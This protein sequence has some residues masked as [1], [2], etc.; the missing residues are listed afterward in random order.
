MVLGG[1]KMSP[2]IFHHVQS[3]LQFKHPGLFTLTAR[4][5]VAAS[6]LFY[7]L[8]SHDTLRPWM[9]NE[10]KIINDICS[11]YTRQ[12]LESWHIYVETVTNP[13]FRMCLVTE[14]PKLPPQCKCPGLTKFILALYV[15]ATGVNSGEAYPFSIEELKARH[16][17]TVVEF[18][19]RTK[20]AMSNCLCFDAQREADALLE[21]AWSTPMEDGDGITVGYHILKHSC[22]LQEAKARFSTLVEMGLS[23]EGL[24]DKA[25]KEAKVTVRQLKA[26]KYYQFTI[27]RINAAFKNL[28]SIC[29]HGEEVSFTLTK[30]ELWGALQTANLIPNGYERFAAYAPPKTPTKEEMTAFASKLAKDQ[31]KKAVASKVDAMIEECYITN[32]KTHHSTLARIIPVQY[33]QRFKQE[34]GYDI[35][36]DWA[37]NSSGL[38]NIACCSPECAFYL[39]PLT[40]KTT[41]TIC[42]ELYKHLMM[43]TQ[44][45]PL[46]GFH[47]TVSRFREG[48]PIRVAAK[49]ESGECLEDPIPNRECLKNLKNLEKETDTKKLHYWEH[50]KSV[51]SAEKKTKLILN[52]RDL[53]N[54]INGTG[55]TSVP[56]LQSEIAELQL[57]FMDPSWK[58]DDFKQVFLEEYK[59]YPGLHGDTP[60]FTLQ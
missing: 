41:N 46:P 57:E 49:V 16:H 11:G 2:G 51:I 13:D 60:H 35:A 6:V 39:K 28:A 4:L 22:T 20:I 23:V 59:K 5:A 12:L 55:K 37:V 18:L 52:V 14:S 32:H 44:A 7:L 53:C 31:L 50:R 9:Q 15:A 54:E 8:G 47:K 43:G 40:N 30:A 10:F 21:Q 33:M 26:A 34:V 3:F 38:S 25:V 45:Q 36:K 27:A 19:A 58:Y 17:S 1:D 24:T 56:A 42:P 29:G 48:V